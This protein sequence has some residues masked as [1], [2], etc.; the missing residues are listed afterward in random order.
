MFKKTEFWYFSFFAG[1]LWPG[2]HG[3]HHERNQHQ[4]WIPTAAADD[5]E[6]LPDDGA[7]A[8]AAA[9]ADPPAEGHDAGSTANRWRHR[10]TQE[11]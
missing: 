11:E 3:S 10:I 4:L 7:A 1:I 8:A 2:R 5:D 6:L 9:A